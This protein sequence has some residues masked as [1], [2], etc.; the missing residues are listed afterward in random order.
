MSLTE[1]PVVKVSVPA[2]PP[3]W[4]SLSVPEVNHVP[5][6]PVDEPARQREVAV[7]QLPVPPVAAVV[8]ASAS[9]K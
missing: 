4:A 7:S 6:V 9:Q 5:S 8:S 2:V 1:M 3:R